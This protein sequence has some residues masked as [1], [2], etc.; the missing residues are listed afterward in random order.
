VRRISLLTAA[1]LAVLLSAPPSAADLVDGAFLPNQRW[2]APERS[3]GLTWYP[4]DGAYRTRLVWMLASLSKHST[5]DR[6]L[7]RIDLQ[8]ALDAIV[9]AP[10]NLRAQKMA[11][12]SS[13]LVTFQVESNVLNA[14]GALGLLGEQVL[15]T[16]SGKGVDW[17]FK[18]AESELISWGLK[19]PDYFEGKV[20]DELRDAQNAVLLEAFGP[21]ESL[22]DVPHALVGPIESLSDVPHALVRLRLRSL[23]TF[24]QD[25]CGCVHPAGSSGRVFRADEAR[26]G[27]DRGPYHTLLG[28]MLTQY[29][30]SV[31]GVNRLQAEQAR[32]EV[33]RVAKLMPKDRIAYLGALAFDLEAVQTARLQR[34]QSPGLIAALGVISNELVSI[35]LSGSPGAGFAY[36]AVTNLL[37]EQARLEGQNRILL[38]VE[39]LR[40]NVLGEISSLAAAGDCACPDTIRT[41]DPRT[42]GG[43]MQACQALLG[44]WKWPKG[45]ISLTSDGRSGSAQATDN[46][47]IHSGVWRCTGPGGLE[48][49][50]DGGRFVDTG[51]LS[52]GTLSMT[53][54]HGYRFSSTRLSPQNE[55]P[56]GETCE[57]RAGDMIYPSACVCTTASGATYTA[58]HAT[59]GH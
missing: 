50:W 41:E 6:K 53:N 4:P 37:D 21:I 33:K 55:V 19:L 25:T 16:L 42:A 28:R 20:A 17:A 39:N 43:S 48:I 54:Q 11:D 32:A 34:G 3:I 57:W 8:S 24:L 23:A 14:S 29:D 18:S 38:D 45:T 51:K 31:P 1:L 35:G 30:P 13:D 5:V 47:H 36:G 49:T 52:G 26:A 22:S 27:F 59:C 44:T 2:R 56:T 9:A 58:P 7:A 15:T 10:A 40:R 46:P 12:L